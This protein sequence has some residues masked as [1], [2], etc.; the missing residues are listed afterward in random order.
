MKA[1]SKSIIEKLHRKNLPL[2]VESV[3]KYLTDVAGIRIICPFLNDIYLLADCFLK[4]DDVTLIEKKDY[5]Q[6]P[7]PN[8]Y[9][10]LHLIIEIPIFLQDEKRLMK[11]E[12]QLRTIA[13]D[14]WASLEHRMRYKKN[15]CE[16][17]SQMLSA[18]LKD[19][20]EASASLDRR[21]GK[22]KDTI[23]DHMEEEHS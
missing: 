21:M 13:M 3:E 10:S 8:G 17:L 5:I 7:K 11:V 6:N 20:A 9:R 22:I 23:E 4:Q 2:E 1:L 19:C 18:E 15:L 14:F 16:E 12:V